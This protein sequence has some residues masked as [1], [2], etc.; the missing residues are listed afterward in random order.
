MG[1][2]FEREYLHFH[3]IRRNG[4]LKG[5]GYAGIPVTVFLK[6]AKIE[7]GFLIAYDNHR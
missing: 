2:V 6:L 4:P 1:T 3:M 7:I 5:W